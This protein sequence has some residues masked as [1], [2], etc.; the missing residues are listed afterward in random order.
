MSNQPTNLQTPSFFV[1]LI[2]VLFLMTLIVINMWIYGDSATS[3]P[4]QLALFF[5]AFVALLIG[6]LKY[7]IPYKN[8][9]GQIIKSISLSLQACTILFVVGTIIG[10]WILSGIVPG[11]IYYGLI[12]I[13]P[14]VFLPLT[15]IVCAIV[16]LSTGSSWST[17]GTIGIALI[18]IGQALNIPVEMVAGAIISGAYFGDKMS[19]LSDT[20]NLA[21]AMA[22]TDIFTHI[23]HMMYTTTPAIIIAIIGFAILGAF[24]HGET[25]TGDNVN[26]IAEILTKNFN[27]TPLLLLIPLGVFVM[28]ILKVPALPA[29]VV[30]TILGIVFAFI[31]QT[32]LLTSMSTGVLNFKEGYKIVATTLFDGFSI[33]TGNEI[34]DSLLNKGG[35]KGMLNTVWLIIMAMIFGGAMEGTGM[36]EKLATTIMKVVTGTG[37]LIGSTIA[38]CI[39]VNITACDQYLAIVVPGR[40]FKRS[41]DKMNLHPKNLSRALEDSG[42]VTS[43]LVPWNTC[44][45]YNSGVLGVST[46]AYLPYCFFNLITPFISAAYGAFN[47]TIERLNTDNAKN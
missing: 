19:P 27:I 23:R 7:K 22:G 13:H 33:K 1:S 31:F 5:S 6:V 17:T 34:I 11:I 39:F 15:C 42:T 2:P 44:A 40:M 9:E 47:I 10:S 32:D 16:S 41:Y 36:L 18:G 46:L 38:T 35:M 37:S 28:I 30:A 4:N 14:I 8:L 43:V 45:A 3:G 21:P 25:I 24:Y 12:L 20:T 29:L 26:A